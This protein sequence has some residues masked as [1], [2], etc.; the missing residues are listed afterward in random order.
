MARLRYNI[1]RNTI[2][3]DLLISDTSI[4]FST[5]LQEG[6]V[7][8]PT[9]VA[10]DIIAMRIGN[11]VMHLTAYTSGATTGTVLRAQED[12]AEEDHFAGDA[13][14]NV[15]TKEDISDGGGD[16]LIRIAASD[17]PAYQ[18]ARADYL[19]DGSNDEA[20]F[21]TAISDADALLT[22]VMRIVL[23][24]SEGTF[25][26]DAT[27]SIAGNHDVVIQGAAPREHMI[28]GAGCSTFIEK[29]A[30]GNFSLITLDTTSRDLFV[31]YVQF[32]PATAESITAAAIDCVSTSTD[33]HLDGCEFYWYGTA[34]P[35]LSPSTGGEISIRG[36]HMEGDEEIILF[37]A[38]SGGFNFTAVDSYFYTDITTFYVV[39]IQGGLNTNPS[40]I[41]FSG[42]RID[43][44]VRLDASV[45]VLHVKVLDCYIEA[46]GALNALDITDADDVKIIG[47][48]ITHDGTAGTLIKITNASHGEV[49]GNTLRD[50]PNHGIWVLDA[51]QVVISDNVIRE[52]SLQTNN[53][54]SG[55][56]LDG[57]TNFCMIEGN[58][59]RSIGANNGL[60]G[61]RVDDSTCDD[62]YIGQNSLR[63]SCQDNGNE[64]SDLGTNTQGAEVLVF[65][66][67]DE[68]TAIAATGQKLSTR[69]PYPFCLTKCRASLNSASAASGPFTIDIEEGGVSVFTTDLLEIDDTELTSVTAA[70][71]PNITDHY[72]A[73]DAVITF[74]VDDVGDGAATGAKVTLYGWRV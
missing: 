6:G 22:G 16:F 64:V 69:M 68:T 13:V 11:E 51:D 71:Q 48:Y 2:T 32:Y 72:L 52:Y 28:F 7:N 54:Y 9:I 40:P 5:A 44:A 24:L 14:G 49:V 65:A 53:T 27:L 21:A 70:T 56:I 12:T 60:Y 26:F 30:S 23:E 10:P 63:G 8:I 29:S 37:N 1:L 66:L 4:D 67:S 42:C 38:P 25:S 62:N 15:I 39:D 59:L 20:T 47:N 41:I 36:C 17:A 50:S 73:D 45:A 34:S 55:I 18:Q 46:L 35:C 61:I 58:V 19:C 43:G 74:D 33:L 31:K 3:T 57:D